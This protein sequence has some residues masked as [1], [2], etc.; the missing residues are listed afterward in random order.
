MV[1]RNYLKF[2]GENHFATKLLHTT[3][4]IA[5]LE[6]VIAIIDCNAPTY[7]CMPDNLH[8]TYHPF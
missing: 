2:R 7:Q 3:Q 1:R 6:R 8:I 4:D 5:R